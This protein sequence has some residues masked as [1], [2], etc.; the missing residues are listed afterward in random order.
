MDTLLRRISLPPPVAWALIAGTAGLL[1]LS[2]AAVVTAAPAAPPAAA[3]PDSC[4]DCHRVLGGRLA[5]PVLRIADDIHVKRGFSC[6]ACHGGDPRSPGL[7]AMDPRK[8]FVGRLKPAQLP[9]LCGRCHS[10]PEVM[11]R[12]N[13]SI[14]T[15]EV[16]RFFSSVH[17]RRLMQGD[18]RAATCTSCHGVHPILAASDSRSS[19]FPAN[20]P[21]TCAR[22]HSDATAMKPYG[23]PTTQLADYQASVHGEALLKRG[24]KQAPACND[25]HGNH[26]AVPPGVDSVAN[27]CAQC[28]R[29][30]RDLFVRSPHRVAFEAL[31]LPQCSV[32][33]GNHRI[34]RP[35]DEMVGVDAPAVCGQCH[36]GGS[37][38]GLVAGTIRTAL[39]DL[40]TSM[41]SA[42]EIVARAENA[43]LDMT[44]AKLPL[45]DAKTQLILARN[46]VH[47]LS[48]TEVQSAATEGIGFSRKAAD[49]GRAG[50]A[51][52][53]FRRRGLLVALGVMTV[54]LV[55]LYLKTR[56]TPGP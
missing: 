39:E 1:W 42:A 51:E 13:P 4:V 21:A 9:A 35:T 27:V 16:A 20:V 30:P 48:L 10:S 45:S 37:R 41:A 54:L 11:R 12:F 38:A 29:S 40:K 28:H 24:S 55:G 18:L 8:G 17:G 52:I 44:D 14:P 26:G 23:I 22:C 34:L 43:G 19:V 46:L 53:A 49:L 50:L 3:P 32:C 25:C 7:E 15:D 36:A 56:T 31:G 6:S 2:Q 47:G 5:E 33:H